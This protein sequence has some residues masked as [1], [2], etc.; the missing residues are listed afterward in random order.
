[1]KP[2][3]NPWNVEEIIIPLEKKETC[4][5]INMER[6]EISELLND[7][8]VSRFVTKMNPIKWLRSGQYSVNKNIRFKT[9]VLRS[10]LCDFSNA[11]IVVKETITSERDNNAKK[12]NKN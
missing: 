8:T 6:Y 5:I 2:D 1:M 4:I 10:D 12:R 11:F 9:S 7:S 3:E